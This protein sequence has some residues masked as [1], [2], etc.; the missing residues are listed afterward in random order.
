MIV[1]PR[2]SARRA[3]FLRL[4]ATATPAGSIVRAHG[5]VQCLISNLSQVPEVALV[6]PASAQR[7]MIIAGNA[8][9]ICS[10]AIRAVKL[11][12]L[13]VENARLFLQFR[14][15]CWFYFLESLAVVVEAAALLV[16]AVAVVVSATGTVAC[17]VFRVVQGS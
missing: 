9:S 4:F 3:I 6:L 10:V 15:V 13:Q 16:A 8:T 1:V 14:I 17:A 7:L 5:C 11:R 12:H 2:V